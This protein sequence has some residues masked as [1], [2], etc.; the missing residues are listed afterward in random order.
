MNRIC[1]ITDRFYYL[2]PEGEI[3]MAKGISVYIG[4]NYT[5]EENLRYVQHAREKGFSN[6]FASLHIAE[7][8]DAKVLEGFK[9]I[10]DF[11]EMY[12][13]SI[14]ADISP[15]TFT[16]L[17][18]DIRNLKPL[19]ELG[20]YGVR[21]NSGFTAEEI[22]EFTKNPYGL[23][24]EINASTVTEKF[25]SD[26]EQKGKP[27]YN[28]IQACH[29]YY[30]RR[31]TGI[32]R[33]I[34]EHRNHLLRQHGIHHIAAFIP[35][36]GN[37]Q[38][39]IFEGR[40]TLEMHREM[41]PQVAAKHLYALGIDNV[42]FGDSIP[43]EEEIQSVGRLDEKLMELRM[44]VYEPNEMERSILFQGTHSSRPDW[45]EDVVRSTGSI[46]LK[47]AELMQPHDTIERKI[48][49]VT[50]DNK[51]YLDYCGE[52]QICKR[53]LPQDDRVNVV[54]RI[55]EEEIFL[56]DY[57]NEESQFRLMDAGQQ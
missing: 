5:M 12:G 17:E 53:D 9:T 51:A 55:V 14:I 40:P 22:A 35:S 47:D 49:Y 34:F 2:G 11:A 54:G 29:S 13:M 42:V 30:S 44:N 38:E 48:G 19:K 4:A 1:C 3:I 8:D 20:L 46:G 37:R 15:G 28:N 16:H 33:A 36:Q 43:S 31:N 10:L 25:L 26:F 7:A 50:I 52:L 23:K 45:A 41:E 24:I 32:S 57:I 6:I 56:L 21:V 18:W 39:P 27:D